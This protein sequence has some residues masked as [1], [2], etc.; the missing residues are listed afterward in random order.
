MCGIWEC[1]A[2]TGLLD[3]NTRYLGDIWPRER[4]REREEARVA[5]EM[6]GGR[7]ILAEVGHLCGGAM[8]AG[9][10]AAESADGV[11]EI[12]KMFGRRRN[13]SGLACI[14]LDIHGDFAWMI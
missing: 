4:I 10:I 6:G 12:L 5:E 2:L 11:R 1:S 3:A 7:Q 8:V 14:A 9:S 13:T